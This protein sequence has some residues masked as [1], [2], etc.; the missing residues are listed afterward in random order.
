MAESVQEVGEECDV[1]GQ[2]L[3]TVEAVISTVDALVDVGRE[4]QVLIDISSYS[5]ADKSGQA[6]RLADKGVVM[7]DCDISGLPFMRG[8]AASAST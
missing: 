6:L 4:D 3:P 2:S 1:I 5:L 7:L 8:V